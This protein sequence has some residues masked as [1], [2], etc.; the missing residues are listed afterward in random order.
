[1]VDTT[2]PTIT[3]SNTNK[4][5][6]LGTGWNFDPPSATDIGGTPIVTIVSTVTNT[7]GHCSPT[8]DA[9]RTWQATDPCGNF[10][11]CSQKVTV[12]DTTAPVIACS[13][14]NKTVELGAAWTFDTPTFTDV[15]GT[16]TLTILSTV[17]NT[18]SHCGTTFDTT[19]MWQAMDG[20][21]NLSRCSQTITVQDTTVPTITCSNTNKIVDMGTAWNFDAPTA[22]DLSGSATITVI[23]TV[24]NTAGHCGSTFDATR[25]WQATD[26]C[27]NF[28]RCSQNV[29]VR[30]GTVPTITCSSTNKTVELGTAWNFDAPTATDLSGTAT[31]TVVSTITNTSGHCGSSFD[32]TRTWQATDACGNFSRCSQTVNVVDSTSP[33]ITCSSTSKTVECGTAWT[34]DAPTASDT[35]GNVTIT[36]VNTFTN[37]TGFCGNTF[38]AVRIWQAT[39]SCG[40]FSR[41]SQTVT[42]VD[43]APPTMSC[44]GNKTVELGSAWSFDTP[45]ATDICG[46]PTVVILSTTTNTGCGA[47]FSATR[48]WQATDACGNSSQCSQTI[49]LVDTIQPTVSIISPTNNTVFVVPANFTLLADAQDFGGNLAKVE[50]FFGT[51]KVGEANSGPPFFVML[52]NV[53]PGNYTVTAKASDGC[54]NASASVGVS[55][56]IIE[57]PPLVILSEIAYNPQTDFF[58]QTVRV[59][60]PTYSTYEAVRVYVSNLTN[61]PAIVVHNASGVTNGIPYVESHAEVPPG[62]YV[63]MKIEYYSPQRVAPNPVLT[64]QL[65]PPVEGSGAAVIGFQQH[66]NRG[67]F[68]PNGNFMVEFASM[69]NRLYYVQY[70]SDLL[71]WKTASPPL[72]GT[73]TWIQWLDNGQPKTESAPASASRRFYRVLLLP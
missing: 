58:E 62:S 43:T 55:I 59:T 60:N 20:C 45:A 35:S 54:G 11:R 29:T 64:P 12:R 4:T 38:R 72:T 27:G 36:V 1:V 50:F 3:C 30:D 42:L 13:N 48:T 52:T 6:E 37:T 47:T 51:T 17:T 22:T 10:S 25:T 67:L 70:S 8:F 73:G 2:V 18:T 15:S 44:S 23:N 31:I 68:L 41:C 66:I 63:D 69:P 65:V 49:S 61:S 46:P 5:I 7:V 53:A 24:T 39:D 33:V 71:T 32:A 28:S 56:R 14:A 26:A 16:A 9:T 34:F 21:G 19:R 40:N 57:K